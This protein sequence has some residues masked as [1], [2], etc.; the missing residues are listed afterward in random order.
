MEEQQNFTMQLTRIDPLKLLLSMFYA[1]R[2]K[3]HLSFLA[4]CEEQEVNIRAHNKLLKTNFAMFL[5]FERVCFQVETAK[6]N[7]FSNRHLNLH[8]YDLILSIELRRLFCI[9]VKNCS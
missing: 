9:L 1:Q 3:I 6:E 7:V 4:L 8:K 2:P 5:P